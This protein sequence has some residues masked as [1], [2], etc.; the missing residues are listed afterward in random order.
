EGGGAETERPLGRV[1]VDSRGNFPMGAGLASSAAGFAALALAARAA[2]GLSTAPALVSRLAREGS[3]S[4]CRSVQGGV[5]IWHRGTRAGGGDS[6][7]APG[8]PRSR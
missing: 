3:G 6:V 8:F 4:A 5:C 1:Q 2:A 7:R